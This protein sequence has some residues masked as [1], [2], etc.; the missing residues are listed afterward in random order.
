LRLHLASLPLR[1]VP[2]RSLVERINKW[3]KRRPYAMWILAAAGL[4]A[5][6]IGSVGVLN[7]GQQIQLANTTL[8]QSEH[9]LVQG[10]VAAGK[11]HAQL[12]WDTLTWVPW[13][14]DLKNRAKQQLVA[15]Q[16]A[17]AVAGL[18][19]LVEKLRFYDYQPLG[20]P[21]LARLAAGCRELWESRSELLGGETL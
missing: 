5:I 15:I 16:R 7:Y 20:D 14:A 17:K 2:N 6:V 10:D 1:G 18:H 8:A 3:R 19:S 13:R 9:E 21:E 11:D 12:A 4:A